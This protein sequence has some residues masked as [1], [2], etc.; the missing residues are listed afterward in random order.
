[1]AQEPAHRQADAR[2]A[3]ST[4][5]PTGSWTCSTISSAASSRT[6]WWRPRS[7]PR[8]R[9]LPRRRWSRNWRRRATSS[10]SARARFV[11]MT[12]DGAVRALVGGRNYAESQFNRAVAAKRQPGSAF[13]PFVYLTALERGLTPDTHA[14]R[15]ADRRQGLEAGELHPRIFRAGDADAGAGEVAQHRL[16]APDAR[17][18]GPK[19]VVRTAHRL[20][21]ASPLEPN[22]SIAL[23]TSEVSPARAGLGLR[24]VR[25]WRHWRSSRTWSS[26]CAAPT[27]RRS[28][29]ATPQS[30]GRIVERAPRRHDERD[31]AR[32][33]GERHRP[34][35]RLRRAG[36]PPARPARR[37]IS[38]TPGSSATPPTS[39]TGVW[40]GNDDNSPTRKTTGGGLP[41]EIWSR[42]M[43]AGAPGRRGRRVARAARRRCGSSVP[44]R[45]AERTPPRRRPRSTEP[46]R[47]CRPMARRSTAGCIDRLFG[48]R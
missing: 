5:S 40:L 42:F 20:G 21:I 28:I 41:V 29:A 19:A 9:P 43:K 26:A 11:A 37:R 36:R 15:P 44:R 16:G 31:A 24:A 30:L 7:I 27:A 6:S 33:A 22:A 12:P 34:Q 46:G 23:G 35:G 10:A 1:M 25:Q 45:R 38:A 14:R 2:P 8:C 17:R 48:R 18:S 32:D 39:S 47:P 13:K 3:R 4:M